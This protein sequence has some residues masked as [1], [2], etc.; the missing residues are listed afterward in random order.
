MD[1][2]G[3]PTISHIKAVARPILRHRIVINYKAKA[4]GLSAD[5]IIEH[6]L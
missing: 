3:S 6:L 5:D 1:G 4:E 2:Q